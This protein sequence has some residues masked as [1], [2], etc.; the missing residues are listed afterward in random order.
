M[1]SAKFTDIAKNVFF[2]LEQYDFTKKFLIYSLLTRKQLWQN[3][4]LKKTAIGAL[5]NYTK[6]YTPSLNESKGQ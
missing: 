5:K 4:N 1:A 2:T 3:K 6:F